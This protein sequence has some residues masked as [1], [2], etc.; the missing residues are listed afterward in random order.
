MS[1]SPKT[2]ERVRSKV[3]KQPGQGPKGDC[4]EWTG[5]VE[6]EDVGRG[7]G[8]AVIGGKNKKAHRVVF[9]IETGQSIVG[10]II[11]H[12]CNNKKCCNV[13]HL[14]AST[15]KDNMKDAAS[16]GLLRKTERV[17]D[18]LR[19][20]IID[21]YK[22]EK[23]ISELSRR[24]KRDRATISKLLDKAGVRIRPSTTSNEHRAM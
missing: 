15:H 18:E 20:E 13:D 14:S 8:K 5:A 12:S 19:R 22:T 1:Y 16:D 21:A 9:E 11:K 7:Y 6:R 3:N 10:K 24:F 2:I 4:H 17:S 23:R